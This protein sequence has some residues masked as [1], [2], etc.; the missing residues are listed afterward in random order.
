MA[1]ART[2]SRPSTQMLP[3]YF[4]TWDN[5]ANAAVQLTHLYFGRRCKPE[6]IQHQL[7]P[8]P[9]RESYVGATQR[10][11]GMGNAAAAWATLPRHGQRCRGMA[12][13][14]AYCFF[15]L[16]TICFIS[17][18]YVCSPFGEDH[19]VISSTRLPVTP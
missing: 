4:P 8:S 2:Q 16:E 1:Q 14:P 12:V 15:T 3:V 5:A 11:R 9:P 6:A 18:S 7:N 17:L 10:C 19:A 13:P